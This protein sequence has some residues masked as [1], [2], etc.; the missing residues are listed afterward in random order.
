MEG[1]FKTLKGALQW[2]QKYKNKPQMVGENGYGKIK[3]KGSPW[4]GE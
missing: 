1:L 4:D 3:S 2:V